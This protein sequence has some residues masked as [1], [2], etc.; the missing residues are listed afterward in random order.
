MVKRQIRLLCNGCKNEMATTNKIVWCQECPHQEL[1]LSIR[2][3]SSKDKLIA[4]ASVSIIK[5]PLTRSGD[6]H[7]LLEVLSVKPAF[8]QRGFG[9][10]MMKAMIERVGHLNLKVEVCPFGDGKK[11]SLS[12]LKRF[13]HRYGFQYQLAGNCMYRSNRKLL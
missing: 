1:A 4:L 12:S 6:K 3:L 11:M 7:A 13:Y 8:R 10:E 2:V 5:K 9:K